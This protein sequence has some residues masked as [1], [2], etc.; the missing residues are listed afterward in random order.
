MNRFLYSPSVFAGI[1]LLCSLLSAQQAALSTSAAAVVPRACGQNSERDVC[2]SRDSARRWSPGLHPATRET[3]EKPAR[4]APS[5]ASALFSMSGPSPR[6][7]ID[8]IL[9]GPTLLAQVRRARW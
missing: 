5:L 8:V 6:T 4:S 3:C 7:T 2:A 9:R 1:L